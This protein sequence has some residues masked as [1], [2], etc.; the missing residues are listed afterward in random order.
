[1]ENNVTKM[2]QFTHLSVDRMKHVCGGEVIHVNKMINF[3]PMCGHGL[4]DD[5]IQAG[6]TYTYL[7]PNCGSTGTLPEEN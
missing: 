5:D 2:R 1:M 4:T 6:P 3:C 7:C